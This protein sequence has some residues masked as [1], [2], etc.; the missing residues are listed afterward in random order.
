MLLLA[1]G[2]CLAAGWQ[3]PAAWA[4]GVAVFGLGFMLF[5][6]RDPHREVVEDEDA[7]LAGADGV[8]RAVEEMEETRYLRTRIVRIGTFLSVFNVHVNRSPIAGNVQK[9]DY[10][11]GRKLFAFLPAASEYNENNAILIHGTRIDCLVRQIV[12]PIA[13]RVVCWCEPGSE[14]AQGER[15]G[16]MRFGSRL[17]VYL[18]CDAVEVVVKP[19]DRV[20]AGETRIAVVRRRQ[21]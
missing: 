4:V 16:I 14:L 9:L 17:D 18:P 7:I 13:R 5:F 2:V 3:V 12:G 8:I 15:F 21:G 19:G 20:V 11:P 10:C 6:F 1:G